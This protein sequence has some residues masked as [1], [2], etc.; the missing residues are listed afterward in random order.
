MISTTEDEPIPALIRTGD[1]VDQKQSTSPSTRN[2]YHARN[3]SITLDESVPSN[4]N[5]FPSS[6][7]N[8]HSNADS[9]SQSHLSE[10][11]MNFRNGTALQGYEGSSSSYAN[12]FDNSLN[13]RSN[14]NTWSR[15]SCHGYDE[16][17]TETSTN[18]GHD[19][20]VSRQLDTIVD[21]SEA[22]AAT[23]DSY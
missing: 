20:I 22:D 14:T 19:M 23:A 11:A 2:F 5:T 1:S 18:N 3:E 6:M 4:T 21:V 7:N 15:R 8:I 16:S 10:N 9:Y 17:Q 12:T 13:T